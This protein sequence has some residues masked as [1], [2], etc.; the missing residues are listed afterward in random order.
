MAD[1]NI[2]V[3]QIQQL[4]GLQNASSDDVQQIQQLLEFQNAEMLKVFTGILTKATYIEARV[5][6]LQKR[7]VD[8]FRHLTHFFLEFDDKK[9]GRFSF[10]ASVKAGLKIRGLAWLH[11]GLAMVS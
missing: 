11:S 2:D 8:Q 9:G 7:R 4:L 1:Q 5:E 3:Q 6:H 10:F